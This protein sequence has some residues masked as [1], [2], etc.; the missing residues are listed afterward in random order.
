MKNKDYLQ[1]F[2]PFLLY[3]V[4][5]FSSVFTKNT[6]MASFFVSIAIM[7]NYIIIAIPQI[8]LILYFFYIK[9]WNFK[10]NFTSGSIFKAIF[11]VMIY[12][13]LLLGISNLLALI[14]IKSGIMQNLSKINPIKQLVPLYFLVS[15]ITGYR[16]ELFFRAYLTKF[17]E[18]TA[19]KTLL[20]ISISAMF[21]IC[22]I[23]QG[24]GG[25]IISFINSMLLCFIFFKHKNIHINALSHAL[26]N[27]SVLVIYT[28]SA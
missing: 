4:L 3:L 20:T 17:F 2:E 6:V 11:L 7:L 16:E 1:Y 14:L 22:H 24:T 19:N 9:K 15:I 21:A 27:F 12:T 10:D 28:F 23:S 13:F 8:L 18:K 25:I 26:Y 5:F